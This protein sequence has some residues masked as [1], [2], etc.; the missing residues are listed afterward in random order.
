MIV[1]FTGTQEG[2]T[3]AQVKRLRSLLGPANEFHHGDCIGADAEA[4]EVAESLGLF[5]V[6][7]PPVNSYKRAFKNGHVVLPPLPFLTRNHEIVR[8]CDQLLAAP[9]MEE[10]ELRSGTWATVRFA[11]KRMVPVILLLPDGSVR[12]G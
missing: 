7:H 4:H 9:R 8:V 5:I 3:Q 11:R 1:G 10:E 6:V 12:S 2:M